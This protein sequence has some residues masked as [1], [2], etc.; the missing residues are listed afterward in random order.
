M[1]ALGVQNLENHTAI[2]YAPQANPFG[3]TLTNNDVLTTKDQVGIDDGN[4]RSWTKTDGFGRTI[5]SWTED[6]QGDVKVST[7]YDGLG[8]AIQTSNPFRP[9]AGESALYTTS[10]FDLAGRVK[11]VTTPDTAVVRTDYNGPRVLVTDQA[12]KQRISKTD[13][14]GRLTDVWEIRSADTVTG[15][16]AVTFPNHSEVT[17]GY[18]TKYS[19]DALDDLTQVTQQVGTTG[20]TQ[21]RTFVYD[22]LKRL[23]SAFNPESGTINY[24]YDP[25]SNLLTKQDVRN[26]TT[27]YIYDALNRVKSRAYMNDPQSTP[28]VA[29][30]Y[31][32][33][34]L[35][36]APSFVPGSS[37]G[38]LLATTYGGASAGNYQGYDQLGRVNVSYQQTDGQNY[39]FTNYT[40]NLASEMAS[41]TY[42]S[43][44]VVVTDYDTAGRIAGVKNQANG[45]YYAGATASDATNRIKY[46]PH[47]AVSVMKLGNGK[48]E[49]TNFN[50]RLQPLQIGLGTSG[51]NSSILQLD[52]GYGATNSNN[53]NVLTQ[54]ITIGAT[55]MTQ[56]YGYDSLNRLSSASE[57][58]AWSQTYDCDRYGNRAVRAGSYIPTP[59]LTPQSVNSTDFSAFSQ[60][61][62]KIIRSGFGYDSAGNLTSDPT[63]AAN[64]M[65]YDAENRQ[66][67]Y[68]KTGVTT[69]YSYDGDGRRVKKVDSTGTIIFLYNA[70][71]QLIAEYHSDPVPPA[72]GGGGTS[73][74]TSDHLGSTRV[75][76]KQDGTVKARY[77]YLPYG[78][79]LGAG[80]GARTTGMG[81]SVADSTKQKFTQ[82]ERDSESGL[83]YF[84]ARYYSSAQGRF[85]SV[86]PLLESARTKHPQTWNRYVYALNNP[87]RYVD[88]TG[89]DVIERRITREYEFDFVDV[90]GDQN[91][92]FHVQ[93]KE[94]TVQ[95]IES[96]TGQV[97]SQDPTKATVGVT[98]VSN[99]ELSR[100][101]QDKIQADI[102]TIG[103]VVKNIVEI[104]R[105]KGFNPFIALGIAA[106]ETALGTT[107]SIDPANRG[108]PEKSP[109][110]N[111][112]QLSGGRATMDPRHNIAGAI[113]D[114][115][116]KSRGGTRSLHDTLD[117]YGGRRY[118][119]A[120]GIMES[121]IH[122]IWSDSYRTF[123][124]TYQDR[125]LRSGFTKE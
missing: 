125:T 13:G 53:G 86:D 4:L 85:T 91:T 29:Y 22:A 100:T 61:T 101:Q 66:I 109:E 65:V 75:V 44:R 70:G 118:P 12:G 54:T 56:S 90:K 92:T 110:V 50:S 122:S 88:P 40:Y 93:V 8:R 123:K 18:R 116:A 28:A 19:Y 23:I 119:I 108:K 82:K 60:S 20:T 106:E 121:Y 117:A 45:L 112:M 69:T 71:G 5:E 74:L 59:A 124:Q 81:Y 2:Y 10:A 14:L 15:T 3:I 96:E 68:M 95:Y 94:E 84:G 72:A 114:F 67:S 25:N 7:I 33:Q 38:R 79:E 35:P 27:T 49:H 46:A 37:I 42:P 78:E 83:D 31:D 63:T 107:R 24:T 30:K 26:I 64:A 102:G 16:E 52:Y 17:A 115:G 34:S 48:W 62:N 21:T 11:T 6:P 76:T 80:V 58:P 98:A 103:R 87:L 1:A 51:T 9:S 47:G 43:G 105:D 55:V 89:E 97:V 36:G 32:S 39:G 41:Q 120:T 73:Y 99:G 113:D 111:P 57:G 104:S 77:D